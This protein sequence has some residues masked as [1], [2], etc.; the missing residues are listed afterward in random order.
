MLGEDINVKKTSIKLLNKLFKSY[1][2]Y[3][4]Q[5][6]L[7]KELSNTTIVINQSI[8]HNK[9]QH[10]NIQLTL[11]STN[12]PSAC[13]VDFHLP[14]EFGSLPGNTRKGLGRPGICT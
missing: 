14:N 4:L 3:S 13:N 2:Y 7:T 9:I 8:N 12:L 1:I 5:S 10:T 6:K 11:S